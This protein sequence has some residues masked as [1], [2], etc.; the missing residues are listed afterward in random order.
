MRTFQ[1]RVAELTLAG[2][3]SSYARN[4]LLVLAYHGVRPDDSPADVD[5]QRKHV[6]ASR[7]SEQM[8]FL[9]E[10]GYCFVDADAL[11]RIAATRRLPGSPAVAVTFDDGYRNTYTEAFPILR[12]LKIPA[13]FYLVTE[14]VNNGSFLWMD[15]LEHAVLTA[16]CDHI[17][18]RMNGMDE[19]VILD[20]PPARS[21]SEVRLREYCK[22]L[23][24]IQRRACLTSVF[25]QLE[26]SD[27]R[28]PGLYRPLS[29]AEV[30][31]MHASGCEFGSHT[32]SHTILS[33]LDEH[34]AHREVAESR[35]AIDAHLPGRC[36]TF[37]YPNGRIGDFND[38]TRRVLAR[39]GF[40]A[41]FTAV[42]GLH[43][44]AA[45]PLRIT[46]IAVNDGMDHRAFVLRITGA[47]GL[48][49]A[50]RRKALALVGRA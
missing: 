26:H 10:R 42:E 19:R 5:P 41:A 16:Q 39:A 38:M 6:R 28:M 25:E 29:W 32:T 37:T 22:R 46:R 48:A 18:V 17:T 30:Q 9:K 40:T 27:Q 20:S 23:D 43:R 21:L 47:F 13:F 15:R 34:A 3:S 14:C 1:A 36:D 12:E 24:P 45:D 49:K 11:R 2:L 44:P 35:D 31:E 4:R 8:A 33:I 50:A 7:F